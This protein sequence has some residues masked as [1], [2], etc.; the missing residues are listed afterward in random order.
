[1]PTTPKIIINTTACCTFSTCITGKP[2]KYNIAKEGNSNT[3]KL[4]VVM[5]TGL[6]SDKNF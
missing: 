4:P 3:R 1:V 2:V 5:L 6:K